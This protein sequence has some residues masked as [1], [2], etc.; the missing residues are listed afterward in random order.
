MFVFFAVL[1]AFVGALAAPY[2]AAFHTALYVD[3]AARVDGPEVSVIDPDSVPDPD[4]DELREG[5]RTL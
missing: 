1:I 2:T 4:P 5:P 3:I